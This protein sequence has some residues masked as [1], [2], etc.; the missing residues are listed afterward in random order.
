M[1]LFQNYIVYICASKPNT[2]FQNWFI[3]L[4][5]LWIKIW[6]NLTFKPEKNYNF[7][8]NIFNLF[9]WI[10]VKECFQGAKLQLR[11]KTLRGLWVQNVGIAGEIALS[12]S[13]TGRIDNGQIRINEKKKY[14]RLK[15]SLSTASTFFDSGER[16]LT[17]A[18]LKNR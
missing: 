9:L 3:F 4:S 16:W 15:A 13:W 2:I 5:T 1:T 18:V 12:S 8:L 7:E 10:L 11:K 14:W 17:S 6:A